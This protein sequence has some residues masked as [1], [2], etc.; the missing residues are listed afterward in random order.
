MWLESDALFTDLLLPMIW[1]SRRAAVGLA[2]V[3]PRLVPSCSHVALIPDASGHL[4]V[5]DLYAALAPPPGD[6]L[7]SPSPPH[8]VWRPLTVAEQA[9]PD[10]AVRSNVITSIQMTRLF[11]LRHI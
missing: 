3:A 5:P 11:A 6:R 1:T 8:S 2:G 10:R 7:V 4:S 9:T